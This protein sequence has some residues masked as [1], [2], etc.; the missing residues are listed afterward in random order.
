MKAKVFTSV[1]LTASALSLWVWLALNL[2]DSATASALEGVAI[3][4]FLVFGGLGLGW[5]VYLLI[6]WTIRD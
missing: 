1:V 6:K 2:P 3:V 5:A 4:F